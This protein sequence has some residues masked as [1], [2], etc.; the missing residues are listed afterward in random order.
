MRLSVVGIDVCVDVSALMEWKKFWYHELSVMRQKMTQ[1]LA[2]PVRGEYQS[3]LLCCSNHSPIW[4]HLTHS[5][6]TLP[7]CYWNK[8][9]NA[10]QKKDKQAPVRRKDKKHLLPTNYWDSNAAQV[11]NSS[12]HYIIGI[13]NLPFSSRESTHHYRSW[14]PE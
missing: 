2:C 9:T 7:Q 4:L 13:R 8:P 6:G 10:G 3:C 11:S 5:P 12:V 14:V 1:T